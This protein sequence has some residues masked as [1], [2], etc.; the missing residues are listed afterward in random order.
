MNSNESLVDVIKV[1]FRWRKTILKTCAA[2]TLLTAL[3]SVLFMRNY[4]R[5]SCVLYPASMSIADKSRLFQENNA[6][7]TY[8]YGGSEDLERLINVAKSAELIMWV[9][10]SFN[11]YKHYGINP[12]NDNAP[13]KV[14]AK[15]NGLYN[16]IKDEHDA[17]VISLED[18]D[19]IMAGNMLKALIAQMDVINK[20]FPKGNQQAILKAYE[21]D[22]QIRQTT[23]RQ[24]TD[25]LT[26]LRKKYGIYDIQMTS[27][28]FS[29]QMIGLKNDLAGKTAKL[30]AY[31][32][33]PANGKGIR[34]SIFK[35]E[36]IVKSVER[37][38]AKFNEDL[39]VFSEG[40]EIVKSIEAQ[41][42]L[43]S[44][45]LADVMEQYN[46]VRASAAAPISS[47]VIIEPAET[48]RTKSRPKRSLLVIGAA[49]LST[50]L[51]IVAI[52]VL[53]QY[54]TINWK[55]ILSDPA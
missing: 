11:L 32:A 43:A 55:E 21:Q 9:V 8:Y 47:L 44:F 53:E 54:K 22:I 4:Y 2:A 39:E 16:I 28:T 37:Q 26:T 45:K 6:N 46:Q 14:K 3:C 27:E 1:V 34:D 25:S 40:V 42:S 38:V 48:P 19:P 35:T 23:L 10:D 18:R 31:R 52:V 7:E 30:E 36:I 13:D 33:A 50:L 5:S 49:L 29:E 12:N 41:K 24:L 17:L 20:R 15:F 51:S